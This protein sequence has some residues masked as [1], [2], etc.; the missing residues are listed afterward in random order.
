LSLIEHIY[1]S[2]GAANVPSRAAGGR[3]SASGEF[4]TSYCELE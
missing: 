1:F 4:S 2:A 3:R